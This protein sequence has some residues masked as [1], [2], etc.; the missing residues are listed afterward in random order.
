MRI[1]MR[2][3]KVMCVMTATLMTG[4]AAAA[5]TLNGSRFIYEEGKKT[6]R[7]K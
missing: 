4:Q 5:F 3:L 6:Y 7:W 1:K 2:L